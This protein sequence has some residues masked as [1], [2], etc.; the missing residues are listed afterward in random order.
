MKTEL[1]QTFLILLSYL[2]CFCLSIECKRKGKNTNS[3]KFVSGINHNSADYNIC[4]SMIIVA[5]S[6]KHFICE[7]ISLTCRRL[8]I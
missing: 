4:K 7:N 1:F 2:L 5:V 6:K 8:L 3:L